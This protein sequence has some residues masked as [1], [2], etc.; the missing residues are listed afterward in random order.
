[1]L[2][3]TC[4]IPPARDGPEA[5]LIWP[6]N[7]VP[8]QKGSPSSKG[9]TFR[10]HR[11]ERKHEFVSTRDW[12]YVYTLDIRHK[13]ADSKGTQTRSWVSTHLE[14]IVILLWKAGSH[15]V[16]DQMLKLN[17]TLFQGPS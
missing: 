3:E 16:F 11:E 1:M 10:A 15:D 13:I 6:K 17:K 2:R 9:I 7:Y 8:E 5:E 14:K 4:N 12:W